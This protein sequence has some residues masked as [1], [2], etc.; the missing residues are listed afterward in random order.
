[1]SSQVEVIEQGD[2]QYGSLDPLARDPAVN[3]ATYDYD[4]LAHSY[5]AAEV[6]AILVIPAEMNTHRGNLSKVIEGRGLEEGTDFLITKPVRS[7]E[8]AHI[9]PERRRLLVRK[10]TSKDMRILSR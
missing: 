5:N 3:R 4:N 2:E 10:L 9:P 1:M 6:N 7:A 8:G